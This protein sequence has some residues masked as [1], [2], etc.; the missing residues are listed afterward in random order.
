MIFVSRDSGHWDEA[1]AFV[2]NVLSLRLR[3]PGLFPVKTIATPLLVSGPGVKH[4]IPSKRVTYLWGASRKSPNH[5]LWKLGVKLNAESQFLHTT[6][7]GQD[8][9][10][11]NL[12]AN[13]KPQW[14]ANTLLTFHY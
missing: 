3:V 11:Q 8:I 14:N 13:S 9:D 12:I 10:V 4:L 2:D 5:A 6:D 7:S 1:T